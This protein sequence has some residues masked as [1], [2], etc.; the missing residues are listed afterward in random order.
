[1][2]APAPT[3]PQIAE[4]V[5]SVVELY[6]KIAG[7][8]GA[9]WLGL[10]K[11]AKPYQEWKR[12]HLATTMRDIFAAELTQLAE[13]VEA[14]TSCAE[15]MAKVLQRQED[16]FDEFDLVIAVVHDTRDRQDETNQLLD[17]LAFTSDRRSN[18]DRRAQV[19]EMI[20]SLH[21]SR[22]ARRRRME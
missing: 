1:M 9:V 17:A 20:A 8:L 6:A 14:E 10:A 12:E 3:D 2:N 5:A 18:G 22:N 11:V 7:A 16:L 4:K 19:D 21:E 15:R 13:A